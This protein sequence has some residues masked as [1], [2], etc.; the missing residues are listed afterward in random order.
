MIYFSDED[1]LWHDIENPILLSASSSG[2]GVVLAYLCCQLGIEVCGDLFRFD[3]KLSRHLHGGPIK[4]EKIFR[5]WI[6]LV[7]LH[8]GAA[9]SSRLLHALSAD[10]IGFSQNHLHREGTLLSNAPDAVNTSR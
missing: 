5:L 3:M 8:G 2:A 7:F 9:F 1:N 10:C 4:S 6:R